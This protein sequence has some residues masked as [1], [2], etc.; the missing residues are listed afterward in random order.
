MSPARL[1]VIAAGAGAR[2]VSLVESVGERAAEGAPNKE[3]E[4]QW[5]DDAIEAEWEH[6]RQLME[7]ALA[8]DRAR[9]RWSG[10]NLE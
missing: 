10:G 5:R 2:A 8:I 9:E 3:A 4:R 1:A 6:I 7:D